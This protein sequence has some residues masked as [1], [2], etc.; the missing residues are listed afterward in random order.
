MG[1]APVILIV[2]VFLMQLTRPAYAI[3][4]LDDIVVGGTYTMRLLT[5]DILKGVIEFKDDSSVILESK[6]KPYKFSQN[7]IQEYSLISA[8]EQPAGQTQATDSAQVSGGSEEI[9][10][11]LL[12]HKKRSSKFIDVTITNGSVFRGIVSEIDRE[13]LK[14]NVDGAIIPIAKSVIAQITLVPD[15]ASSKE[16][17]QESALMDD[18]PLDTIFVVNDKTDAYGRPLDPLVFV[19]RIVTDNSR[20]VAIETPQGTTRTLKRNRILRIN[21]Y[22]ASPY[23]DKIK[24]YAASLFCDEDMV[25]IDLPP[26][27]PDRPFFKVCIDKYEYPN[28]KGAV[29]QG[30]VSYDDARK[31]CESTGK[32]LCTQEEWQWACSGLEGYTYPYGWNLDKKT[33]NTKGVGYIEPS[34]ERPHCVGKFGV[35]DMSGNIFEWVTGEH[36]MPMLMGGPYSKCQTASPGLGG[37]A[38]PQTGFRCC[39]SN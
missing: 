16:E 14:L 21:K 3:D 30:N 36:G 17:S 2:A 1:R 15:T 34:G 22:S 38:K 29:P 24:R 6:G 26:G 5:G 20:G 35:H 8:P 25:L 10:Y 37:Q 19:G 13:Q 28:K 12:L 39:K 7:L 11:E 32:R 27:K 33:C 9:S 31:V 23:E 18:T 4:S